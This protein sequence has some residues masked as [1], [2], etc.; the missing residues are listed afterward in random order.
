MSRFEI[1][2]LASFDKMIAVPLVRV[3]YY[4]GLAAW[5]LAIVVQLVAALAAMR[6]SA[7]AGFGAVLLVVVGGAVALLAWRLLCESMI[8]LFS[9]F[10]RL[11]E[12]RALLARGE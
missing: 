5:A 4:L 1:R 9:I 3:L 7:A 12:I 10:D 2:D 11:G 8:V 6:H